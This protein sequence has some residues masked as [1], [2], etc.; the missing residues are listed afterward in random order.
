MEVNVNISGMLASHWVTLSSTGLTEQK[1]SLWTTKTSC[2]SHNSG[3]EENGITA[4]GEVTLQRLDL[5]R[6][7]ANG[8]TLDMKMDIDIKSI[9]LHRFSKVELCTL[10]FM[11]LDYLMCPRVAFLYQQRT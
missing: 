6:N 11:I 5:P 7:C 4:R 1:R 8:N 10:I 3:E 9:I 2:C